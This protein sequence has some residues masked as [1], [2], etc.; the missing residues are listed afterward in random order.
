MRSVINVAIVLVTAVAVNSVGA[1]TTR[2]H[3]ALCK[4]GQSGKIL[5]TTIEYESGYKVEAPW[6]VT[7]EHNAKDGEKKLTA[8]LDHIIETDPETRKRSLT[9]LP[10]AIEMTFSA[11]SQAA[12]LREAAN[13]WCTTVAKAMAARQAASGSRASADGVIM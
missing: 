10:G 9:P 5:L 12:L 11:A 8:V 1:Q 13:V 3:E 7:V 6:R 4:A 2:N